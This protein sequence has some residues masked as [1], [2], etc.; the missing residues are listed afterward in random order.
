MYSTVLCCFTT[1]FIFAA[2]LRH[3]AHQQYSL[4]FGLVC[5]TD[6]DGETFQNMILS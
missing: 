5:T 6:T 3:L 4:R 1:E 2:P